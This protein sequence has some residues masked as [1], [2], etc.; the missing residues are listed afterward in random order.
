MIYEVKS[1]NAGGGRETTFINSYHGEH[2]SDYSEH[3][4]K[5]LGVKVLSVRELQTITVDRL[6]DDVSH[7]MKGDYGALQMYDWRGGFEFTSKS[8]RALLKSA[9]KWEYP[10]ELLFVRRGPTT[11]SDRKHAA[12]SFFKLAEKAWRDYGHLY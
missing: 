11:L 8:A 3:R 9:L 1:V 2:L 5:E 7:G 6:I 12:R 4:R 10:E